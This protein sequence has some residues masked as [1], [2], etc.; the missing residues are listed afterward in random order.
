M[1]LKRSSGAYRYA[2]RSGRTQSVKKRPMIDEFF[3]EIDPLLPVA[4][5]CYP[6]VKISSSV[7][8]PLQKLSR[9]K[10]LAQWDFLS[11]PSQ[12]CAAMGPLGIDW[13][14]MSLRRDHPLSA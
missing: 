5:V 7:S 13:A 8:P 14:R 6:A 3:N 9:I 12:S 11:Y 10:F 2:R 1:I 4:T